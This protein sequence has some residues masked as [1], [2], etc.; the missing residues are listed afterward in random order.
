MM[1]LVRMRFMLMMITNRNR[2]LEIAFLSSSS[3]VQRFIMNSWSLNKKPYR[4]WIG[5]AYKMQ[6]IL[7]QLSKKDFVRY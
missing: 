3:T 5:A 4:Y 7:L 2:N 1:L 6:A